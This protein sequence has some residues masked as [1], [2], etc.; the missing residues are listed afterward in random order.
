MI[1][2]TTGSPI[3]GTAVPRIGDEDGEH[4]LHGIVGHRRLIPLTTS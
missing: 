4:V 1:R 2:G 3:R